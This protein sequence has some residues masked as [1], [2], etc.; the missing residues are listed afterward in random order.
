MSSI[1]F[2]P[3]YSSIVGN[4][5]NNNNINIPAF[6]PAYLSP[7][8]S[9]RPTPPSYQHLVARVNPRP[10]LYGAH[11]RKNNF[12]HK[13]QAGS[14]TTFNGYTNIRHNNR[15][16][17][18]PPRRQRLGPQQQQQQYYQRQTYRSRSTSRHQQEQYQRPRQPRTFYQAQ[19]YHPRLLHQHI[20]PATSKYHVLSR[21]PSRSPSPAP[22]TTTYRPPVQPRRQQ[23]HHHHHQQQPYRPPRQT[24]NNRQTGLIVSDSMLSRVRTYTIRSHNIDIQLSYESGCDCKR[25]VDWMESAQGRRIV[26]NREILVVSLGTNDVAR[27]GVDESIRRCA[28]FIQYIRRA[29]PSVRT[30]GWMALAPRWKPTRFISAEQI[31]DMHIQFNER[32]RIL[33]RQ[34][35]FDVIDARLGLADIREEDGLH[36]TIT[37]GRWKYE[38]AIRRWINFKCQRTVSPIPSSH[39]NHRILNFNPSTIQR[40]SYNTTPHYHNSRQN[41]YNNS[42]PYRFGRPQN[43]MPRQQQQRQPPQA[44]NRSVVNNTQPFSVMSDQTETRAKTNRNALYIPSRNLIKFY[45]H[46][47]RTIEQ[48]FRENA[49]P[50]EIEQEKD[51]IFE[52]ANIYYQYKHFENDSEKWKIYERVASCQEKE[53]ER[54]DIEMRDIEEIPI[55]RPFPDRH[56]QILNITISDNENN[57]SEDND[58]RKHRLSDLATD[59]EDDEQKKRKL[60][61]TS[62][63]PTTATT[64]TTTIR[65]KKEKV[66]KKKK[67]IENDPRA[68]LGSPTL[69]ITSTGN[70]EQSG[71]RTTTTTE[72]RQDTPLSP[73]NRQN[74][75]FARAYQPQRTARPVTTIDAATSPP[76][77]TTTMTLPKTP[78]GL[79]APP[80]VSPRQSTPKTP[81]AIPQP[82]RDE[83]ERETVINENRERN[84]PMEEEIIEVRQTTTTTTVNENARSVLV[85]FPIIPIEC[86]YHFKNFRLEASI[87]NIRLHREF[88]EKKTD[89]LRKQVEQ[90]VGAFREAKR[91]QVSQFVRESVESL[92]EKVR[93]ANRTR[94]DNV[95]LDQI[96]ERAIKTIRERATRDNIEKIENARLKF[97][98]TLELRFQLDKLDRR[99]NEN[100]PPPALNAMDRLQFRSRELT[101]ETR[102]QYSEQW[103]SVIRKTKLELTSIMRSAKTTEIA[104][105]E[106]EYQEL[107]EKIPIELRNAYRDLIHTVEM[108]H[109]RRH[110]KKLTFLEQKAKRTVEK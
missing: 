4:N 72:R 40:P 50:K 20:S 102:E 75:L 48:F 2:I 65:K 13:F 16:P 61:D 73:R 1:S 55:A 51:K 31:G 17:T 101:N 52:I 105:N 41:N 66:Q 8:R 28:D 91:D 109:S 14:T 34:F 92:I 56:S 54:E 22:T 53:K 81:I 69:T 67:T 25:M 11:Q 78:P 89:Q 36:P 85:D 94:I 30:V 12:L 38:E 45:P 47:L 96:R 103:N 97:E 27:Y 6:R 68:P 58:R 86:R 21:L 33:S 106:K 83:E 88:L 104:K 76:P 10:T 19:Q 80:V 90:L 84:E 59:T 107:F 39:Y 95:M 9:I 43:Q 108:R 32:L 74:R 15:A 93:I 46:K 87:E 71:T 99:L 60:T 64:T 100:M 63:S 7:R 29:H 79:P 57:T 26:S 77:S 3:S 49:P 18:P 35:D 62:L 37:T 110:E 24:N 98:R 70:R 44:M 82:M 23:H 42:S 5:N